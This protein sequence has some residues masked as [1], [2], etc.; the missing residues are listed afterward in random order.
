MI[1]KHYLQ[2][3]TVDGFIKRY[4]EMLCDYETC[5]ETYNAVERQHE[6]AFGKR[7]Y[8]D[9]DTFKVTLSRYSKSKKEIVNNPISKKLT[10]LTK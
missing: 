2:L 9:Y 3:L 5:I 4:L 8:S 6:H 10:M 1:E 7:K